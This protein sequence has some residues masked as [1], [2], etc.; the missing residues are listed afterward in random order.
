MY[1]YVCKKK[2]G[3]SL[4]ELCILI[5]GILYLLTL[6]SRDSTEFKGNPFSGGLAVKSLFLRTLKQKCGFDRIVKRGSTIL[7]SLLIHFFPSHKISHN[8]KRQERGWSPEYL[9]Q[10]HI[11]LFIP[12][13]LARDTQLRWCKIRNES[14]NVS[15]FPLV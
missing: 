7:Q 8:L 1:G 4:Q 13:G 2:I 6:S 11:C 3:L 9:H 14:I 12:P 15:T 10:T 5:T